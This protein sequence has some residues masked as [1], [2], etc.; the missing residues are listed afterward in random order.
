LPGA[1]NYIP[2]P[3]VI[4]LDNAASTAP[5]PQVLSA[6]TAAAADQ[7][8]NPSAAHGLG[9][10]AARALEAARIDV[11]RLC[12]GQPGEIIFTSG[13]TEAN[14]LGTLGAAAVARGRHVVLGGIEHPAVLRS[15]TS[16]QEQG[17]TV[18]TVA[19][20]PDGV[21]PAA[22]IAAALRPDTA[23]V[24]LML[25][26]NELGTVQPVADA[27]TAVRAAGSRAHFHCDAVQIAGLLPVDVRTLG[28]DSLA[29]SAHKLHGPKG[30]G[31]LWLRSGARVRALWDGGRQEKGLRSGTENLP[32]QVG[33]GVAARLALTAAAG[34]QV[35]Q[36]RDQLEALI[37]AAV[38]EARPTV[39]ATAPRAPH[40]ASVTV[41]ALPAEVI[42]HAL[43]A[44]GIFASAGSA[45]ATR[46]KDRSHVLA[47]IGVPESAAV[48]RFSLARTTREDELAPVAAALRAAIDEVAP[49]VRSQ[50]G[51]KTQ[52]R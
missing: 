12:G 11:A 41:P 16:L 34:A 32:A 28:I 27:A 14:A 46:N 25:V 15:V 42:L 51:R 7:Y 35:A 2:A 44:R 49:L 38:P 9:A 39:D 37:A 31:A 8:A 33:F 18:T 23:L 24:A 10:A 6:L 17:F 4:Y 19:P 22:A 13:G 29:L 43:E 20:R 21:V 40:I 3:F 1:I 26:N 47:A 50:P 30:A 45:C 36:L 52:N 5:A 48:L